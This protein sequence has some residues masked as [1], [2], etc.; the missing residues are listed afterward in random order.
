M[1]CKGSFLS[2]PSVDEPMQAEFDAFAYLSRSDGRRH[3]G[4]RNGAGHGRYCVGAGV[5]RAHDLA[6]FCLPVPHPAQAWED[7]QP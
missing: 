7:E 1:E 3:R 5:P 4:D 2:I 6:R